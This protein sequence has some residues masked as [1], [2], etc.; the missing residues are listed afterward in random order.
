MKYK[1]KLSHIMTVI[2]VG[3]SQN[4]DSITIK[5]DKLSIYIKFL[6]ILCSVG[7]IKGYTIMNKFLKITLK[8]SFSQK[9]AIVPITKLNNFGANKIIKYK[10]LLKLY[11]REGG[12]VC[13][14]LSTDLGVLTSYE[15]LRNHIGGKILYRIA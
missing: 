8:K 2:R 7:C 6:D 4:K 10:D 5:Y 14:I 11:F 9:Q 1:N 13:Y 3:M 15:A 12:V